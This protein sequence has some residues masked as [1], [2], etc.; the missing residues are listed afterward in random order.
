VRRPTALASTVR[1]EPEGERQGGQ[2]WQQFKHR[3]AYQPAEMEAVSVLEN[4]DFN[5]AKAIEELE[6]SK[7]YDAGYIGGATTR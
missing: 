1:R 7:K 4:H 6:D 2:Y 3:F 5:R